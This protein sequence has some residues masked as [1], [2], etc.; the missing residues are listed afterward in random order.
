MQL[1]PY[2]TACVEQA[3]DILRTHRSTLIVMATGLGK[4]VT[5][6]ET[7]RRW[8]T[9]RV[10]FMA[11]RDELIRQACDKLQRITGE[12]CDVEM[13]QEWADDDPLLAKSKVVVTSVQTMSRIRRM[14]RFK[15]EDFGL[16]VI[17]EAHRA[18]ARS[19]REVIRYYQQ[20]PDM[21]LVGLTATPDRTDGQ[22]MGLVFDS[23][24]FR[25]DILNAIDDGW[26]V[27]IEQQFVW[28]KGMDLSK[29]KTVAGDFA[30]EELAKIMEQE[31]ICHE[32]ASSTLQLSEGPTLLFT[33]SVRQAEKTAEIL[34]RH[35]PGSADWV[36]GE[37]P[38]DQRRD[39]LARF[40]SG[41]LQYLANC[42]ILTE[43]YDCPS[44][45]TI[46]VARPTKSR[47]LYAQILGRATRPLPNTVDRFDNPELRRKA[48][49]CSTKTA[50][51]VLDLVGNSGRHKLV[52]ALDI[53]GGN[54]DP[55][56]VARAIATSKKANRRADA[57]EALRYAAEAQRIAEEERKRR[58]AII[59]HA[60]I[61]VV[62]VD[63]FTGSVER[64]KLISSPRHRQVFPASTMLF[65]YAAIQEQRKRETN[66]TKAT[67][68][69]A[70]IRAKRLIVAERK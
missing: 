29:L 13:G 27:P 25:Y 68:K 46:V 66:S 35:K 48:I 34:N 8:P 28:V 43:G 52:S 15:P 16:V 56:V 36:C 18:T 54:Y 42:A 58:Q 3:A 69:K 23:V 49:A 62:P 31:R 33:A 60:M 21:K 14:T 4:T 32:I 63:P 17:D 9:G 37:T 40:A 24:A 51:I 38:K 53:L 22:A 11:H 7:I 61:G 67:P 2:Q 1:R 70:L 5:I 64:Q 65:G 45:R 30:P 41:E 19:Y 12:P 10:L 55:I 26:L 59:A 39:I 47:S 44:L 20:N 6:A 50:A 57:L